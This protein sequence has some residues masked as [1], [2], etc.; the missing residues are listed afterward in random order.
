MNI[1]KYTSLDSLLSKTS[2][3][4]HIH[5]PPITAIPDKI[6][7]LKCVLLG[8]SGVG[9]SSLIAKYITDF[10]N[11]NGITTIGA[12]ALNYKLVNILSG[13]RIKLEIWDTAGQERFNSLAPLY[14]RGS[15]IVF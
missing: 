15:N 13:E 10:F 7:T 5:V 1:L 12:A 11:P 2:H 3:D 14:Y 6:R 4:P 8:S 9:K